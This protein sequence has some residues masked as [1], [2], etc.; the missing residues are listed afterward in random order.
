MADETQ[1]LPAALG[2]SFARWLRALA[3]EVERDPELAARV[4]TAA[5]DA[6]P[7]APHSDLTDSIPEAATPPE[8]APEPVADAVPPED[9]A[10][11]VRQTR[12]ASRFGP[13]TIAGRGTSLGRGVPDPFAIHADSGEAG[14]RAALEGLRAGTLRAMIRAHDLDPHA[15]VPASA[16]ETRLAAAILAAVKRRSA[17]PPAPR[18]RAPPGPVPAPT[19]TSAGG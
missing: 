3:S 16:S 6:V 17:P 12:R 13:P 11:A 8:A 5:L 19:D 18:R 2:R 14:L 10:P 7:V 9:A 4:A 1:R 15:K